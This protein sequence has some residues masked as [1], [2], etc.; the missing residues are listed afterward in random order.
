MKRFLHAV[1]II[2]VMRS[3]EPFL[4]FIFCLLFFAVLGAL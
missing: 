3:F 1:K 2:F 4:F